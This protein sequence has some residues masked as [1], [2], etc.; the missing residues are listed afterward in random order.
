MSDDFTYLLRVRY[1]EC[2][3]QLVVF[4]A[5]YVD[6]VDIA[7]TEFQRHLWGSYQDLMAS[8]LDTQLVN[9]NIDWMAPA[10]FD[11]VLRISMKVTRVGNTSFVVRA[12]FHNHDNGE[13]LAGV[14]VTYVLVSTPE[15]SST[16]INDVMRQQLLAGAPG[17]CVDHAGAGG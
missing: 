5:R 13:H 8:G 11:D 10:R 4:N 15:F 17:V 16:P 14:D 3:A 6:Y 12:E 7:L 2:D 9:L 1:S